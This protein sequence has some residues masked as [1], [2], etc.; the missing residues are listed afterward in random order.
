MIYH[1]TSV[2]YKRFEY[3]QHTHND[4]DY[5]INCHITE[6]RSLAAQTIQ[7]TSYTKRSSIIHELQPHLHSHIEL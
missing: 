3:H 5:H 4:D 2:N 6:D 1:Q 7:E